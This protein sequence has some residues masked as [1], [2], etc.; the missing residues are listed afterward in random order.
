MPTRQVVGYPVAGESVLDCSSSLR[1]AGQKVPYLIRTL[2]W[3][4][5]YHDSLQGKV[6]KCSR[7]IKLYCQ[8]SDKMQLKPLHIWN[9]ARSMGVTAFSL[10]K[11]KQKQ[12]PPLLFSSLQSTLSVQSVK[13][14]S[15]NGMP[16]FVIQCSHTVIK[17][18]TFLTLFLDVQLLIAFKLYPPLPLP[19]LLHTWANWWESP[20]AHSFGAG[21]NFKPY[22]GTLTLALPHNHHKSPSLISCPILSRHSPTS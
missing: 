12:Y 19:F 20:G 10:T 11:N 17:N 4:R 2:E 9:C 15:T 7:G 16:S 22:A 5:N 21:E 6:G 14:S 3:M 13:G 1:R 8:G 18:L